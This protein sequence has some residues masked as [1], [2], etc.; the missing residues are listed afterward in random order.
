[1][2]TKPIK[3]VGFIITTM[4]A[5]TQNAESQTVRFDDVYNI[6]GMVKEWPGYYNSVN[7]SQGDVIGNPTI[8]SMDVT[9]DSNAHLLQKIVLNIA[10][11]KGKSALAEQDVIIRWDS[12][13]INTNYT[14]V[15]K[16]NWDQTWDYFVHTNT[17]SS[18]TDGIVRGAK[19][20]IVGD[21]PGKGLY[22]VDDE[23][24]PTLPKYDSKGKLIAGDYGY[25]MVSKDSSGRKF[26]PDGIDSDY[27]SLM[28]ASFQGYFA[29]TYLSGSGSNKLWAYTI[30]YDFSTLKTHGL[31]YDDG[32]TIG[33]TPWCANDAILAAVSDPVPEP[34]TI[35]LLGA[36]LIGLAGLQRARRKD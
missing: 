34:S 14:D 16:T 27:L 23:F 4:L 36:G 35:L 10:P 32:F 25:T 19:T 22:A 30:T 2:H 24:L 18:E 15:T 12:L 11:T 29:S 6:P 20:D 9:Y 17:I 3:I 5:S 28:D 13:F 7:A 31:K 33:Y 21:I 8:N 26:H 1:M